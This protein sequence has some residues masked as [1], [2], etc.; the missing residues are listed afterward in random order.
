MKGLKLYLLVISSGYNIMTLYIYEQTTEGEKNY[1]FRSLVFFYY[2][3]TLPKNIVL[4]SGNLI[5][6]NKKNT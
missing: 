6:P 2:T 4:C 3:K 1:W 5:K